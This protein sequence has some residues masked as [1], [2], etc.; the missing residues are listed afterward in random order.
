MS[1]LVPLNPLDYTLL[2]IDEAWRRCGL[3][4]VDIHL[5]LILR[6]RVDVD[7][8]RRAAACVRR[9][10]PVLAGRLDCGGWLR[11]AGWRIGDGGSHTSD[12]DC[13]SVRS[14]PDD[15]AESL[16]AARE[17]LLAERFEATNG[18]PL[19]LVVLRPP[20]GSDA[21]V[22]R[23]PHFLMDARG[24]A[25]ILEAIAGFFDDGASPDETRS[26][27]DE[28]RSCFGALD[29]RR[30][31]DGTDAAIASN[32]AAGRDVVH[33]VSERRPRPGER[34]RILVRSLSAEETESV[35]AS[36]LATC[37]FARLADYLRACGVATL[38]HELLSNAAAC[39]NGVYTTQVL[40]DNRKRRDPGPVCHNI[41]ST[42][43]VSVPTR[44]A[45]DVAAT[46]DAIRDQTAGLLSGGF[47]SSRLHA[48]GRLCRV[49]LPLLSRVLAWSLRSRFSLLPTGLTNAPSLPLGFM[50]PLSREITSFC[51][52][53]L[54]G[55][56]GVRPPSV[57]S[58]F[59]INV[60]M[61]Q[62]RIN[63]AITGFEPR[64]SVDAL[65]R[66]LNR[67]V[68]LLLCGNRSVP[69]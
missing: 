2:A 64:I 26:A 13:V 37:G 40:V 33:L 10:Y 49:P 32:P 68:S 57:R 23:W 14:L 39:A 28:G 44:I 46:A 6:G 61:A 1:R 29:V 9:L 69:C 17:T 67:Y 62:G 3:P 7:G 15:S 11:A 66:L 53:E 5:H 60:N 54:I 45:G 12:G 42:L 36:A 20:T 52:A 55:L 47:M 27:G 51:G 21:V 19:R 65:R 8:L 25:T 18:S 24:G 58:G 50:G 22:M 63:A 56:F 38:H 16:R 48:I 43:P 35:Q 59:A 30:R 41:F 4:S 31:A 34:L